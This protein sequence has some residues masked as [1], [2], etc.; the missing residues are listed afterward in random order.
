[1]GLPLGW[2]GSWVA[3]FKNSIGMP[4][5]PADFPAMDALSATKISCEVKSWLRVDAISIAAVVGS[6]KSILC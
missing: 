6:G 2:S 1:M 5:T 3:Y 4:S